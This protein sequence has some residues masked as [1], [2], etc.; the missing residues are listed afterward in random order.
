MKHI[1]ILL[2]A[3]LLG[4]FTSFAADTALPDTDRLPGVDLAEGI[5]QITGVAI[6]PLLG[7]TAA[8][9]WRYF[10][11]PSN[12]RARLPWYCQPYI[13]GVGFCLFILCFLKDFF[14][15]AAP[16][17]IKIPL[18]VVELFE[19]KLSALV[20][21][22]AFVPFVVSQMIRQAPS[23]ASS[24]IPAN[25]HYASILPFN[26]FDIHF[27][28]IPL[29]IIGFLIIWLASHAIHVL[30]ALCPFGI[31][32]GI[33]KLSKALLLFSIVIVFLI[34]NLIVSAVV[35]LTILY[36]AGLLAPWAFRLTVFGS[37]FGLDILL[38]GRG[39]RFVHE[40]KPHAFLARAVDKA[41]MR[42]YGHLACTTDGSMIFTYRPWLIF[43]EQ[44]V[45][46]P[47]GNV[48]ISRGFLFPSLLHSI[49]VRQR[50]SSVLMFL[51]RYRS[52]EQLIASHFKIVN[53]QEIP[54]IKGFQAIRQWLAET[55][56]L[57]K[58][59]NGNIHSC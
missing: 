11:T 22:S 58:S 47:L 39:R 2:T 43:S 37:L 53:I 55:I 40:K 7:V 8:G 5:T 3:L 28:A 15:T 9:A 44:S 14:G 29:A 1:L 6:S 56:Y 42:T 34:N 52:H 12:Q 54:L 13:W 17:L 48:A 18:D 20:A 45:S 50:Q 31:I 41:P 30:I 25:V 19:N 36:I 46:I 27:I 38:P 33:F 49:D 51:P 35:T 24:V 32:D 59:K 16:P 4:P 21:C 23:Q 26:G 57:R 10:Q